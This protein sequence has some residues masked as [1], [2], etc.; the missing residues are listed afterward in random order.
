[1][2]IPS[3]RGLENQKFVE[4][5]INGGMIT[6]IDAADIATGQLVLAKNA[7]VRY[8]RTS[9]RNGHELLTPVKP[10]SLRVLKIATLKDNTGIAY[11]YRFT[12]TTLH[13]LN[14]PVWTVLTGALA[15]GNNDRIRTVVINNQFVFSNNGA[16]KPKL[17]NASLDTFADLGNVPQY[18][19]ITGFF[20]RVVGANAVDAT[21]GQ[22]VDIGWSGFNNI[23]EWNNA[24][25]V[26]A[27]RSPLVDSPSDFGDHISGIFGLTNSLVVLR[28]RSLWLGTRQPQINNPFNF[29]NAAPGIGCNSPYSAVPFEKGLI[30]YDHRTSTVWVYSLGGD[31][32]P[33][34]RPVDNELTRGI[35]D[36]AEV[37]AS[38]NPIDNEYI[39]CVPAVGST[40]IRCWTYNFRTKAWSYDEIEGIASADDAD[41]SSGYTSINDLLGTIDAQSG[42]ID[43]LSP[44]ADIRPTRLFGKT[45]GDVLVESQDFAIE[46]DAGTAYET[47]LISKEYEAP[48]ED[49]VVAEIRLEYMAQSEV[50]FELY[51]AKNGAA[52]G[53]TP[54]KTWDVTILNRTK[55]L[56]HVKQYRC[57][58]LQWKLIA[59]G[60][61]F[62][63]LKYEIHIYLSG[64]SKR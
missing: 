20:G 23:A 55:L 37:F 36:P 7:R 30:W 47:V 1:M 6:S 34:G 25:D 14:T 63:L 19:Y 48:E 16:N 54:N 12:P 33:I 4:S 18:K 44:E 3:A 45:N 60:G 32:E 2:T 5:R 24:V 13:R 29:Y 31:F 56:R 46:N 51:V 43:D 9:R 39:V 64:D 11:T 58:Q 53:L 21:G 22:G 28:E 8:D 52:F 35:N 38:Y 40:A 42:N 27:G 49:I 61:K 26:S 17:I 10:N 50:T 41:I 62:D 57:R 15:G 59:N